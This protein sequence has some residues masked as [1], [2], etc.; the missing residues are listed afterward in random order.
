MANRVL[1]ISPCPEDV[2]ALEQALGNARDGPFDVESA[3]T[4]TEGLRL[5][6]L[7]GID[8]ILADLALPESQHMACFDQLFVVARHTP[9]LTLCTL[10][11]EDDA[12]QAVQ[13]GA[14]GWLTKGHFNNFLVPQSLRNIIERMKVEQALYVA[15]A[16]AELTLNSIGDAVVSA[17]MGGHI[18]Y[19]NVAAEK[20]TGWERAHA[21][22][23][24]ISEVLN[25]IESSTGHPISN[26][27]ELILHSDRP[28]DLTGDAV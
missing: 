21:C 16:R 8:A 25:I 18:D 26:P 6:R 9:I 20:I 1:I 7:G 10:D 15:Q 3:T 5:I 19:L 4:L 17:D 24:P 11:D 2:R 27:I 13:R 23:R 12:K 22:G 14:Q 28:M